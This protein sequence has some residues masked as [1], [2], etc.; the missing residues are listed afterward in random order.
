MAAPIVTR[1]RIMTERRRVGVPEAVTP[2]AVVRARERAGVLSPS[3]SL[4]SPWTMMIEG[5]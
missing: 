4:S 1:C 5:A 3:G 2:R